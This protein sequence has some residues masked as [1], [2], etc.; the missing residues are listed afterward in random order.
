MKKNKII[1]LFLAALIFALCAIP[2]QA[3]A[4]LGDVDGDGAI[5][6]EDARSILRF[7][8]N[9]DM[10][11]DSQRISADLDGDGEITASDARAALRLA[12]N[13]DTMLGYVLYQTAHPLFEQ[14]F[15]QMHPNRSIVQEV[16]YRTAN[17]CCFYTLHDVYRPVLK[18]LGYSDDVIE[19]YAP[20]KYS[21]EKIAKV[22]DSFF[23]FNLSFVVSI[24]EQMEWYT[25][26]LLADYY[27]NNPKYA[28]TYVFWEY[29]DDVIENVIIE[30]TNN[31]GGYKPQVGDI[32]FMSNKTESYVDGTPTIDHTAQI[33][34]VNDDGTF[35]CTEGSIIQNGEDGVARV[36]ER[37][38]YYD[39]SKATYVWELNDVV[40]ILMIARPLLP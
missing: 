29:F 17:W 38:Y 21:K 4:S 14:S 28:E 25:P 10:P 9:L 15:P 2:A 31:T 22:A 13:L 35:L 12:V 19:K 1:S 40:N 8:V 16:Y 3:A 34:K 36:R 27:L 24:A 23:G 39:S 33:I 32:V 26:S 18:E 11:S 7:S 5:T 6:A 37:E 20:S 30:P